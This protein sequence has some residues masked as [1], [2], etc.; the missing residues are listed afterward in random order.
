MRVKHSTNFRHPLLIH[1]YIFHPLISFLYGH[2][3][4][5]LLGRQCTKQAWVRRCKVLLLFSRSIQLKPD[6]NLNIYII[7]G[8]SYPD[9]FP[10]ASFDSVLFW[11]LYKEQ[12]SYYTRG[13]A[14]AKSLSTKP[15]VF[16][17][18]KYKGWCSNDSSG[19]RLPLKLLLCLYRQEVRKRPG[20][21]PFSGEEYCPFTY[22]LD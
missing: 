2:Q 16:A 19:A 13:L 3:V 22:V 10:K 11:N 1:S 5:R 9:C 4:P 7:T 17:S 14:Q 18:P 21:F 15:F 20:H 6:G 8:S 12:N